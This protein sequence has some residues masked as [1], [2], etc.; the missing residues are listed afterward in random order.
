MHS[1]FILLYFD[2]MPFTASDDSRTFLRRPHQ[3]SIFIKRCDYNTSHNTQKFLPHSLART[4]RVYANPTFLATISHESLEKRRE[5]LFVRIQT[6][7]RKF[8]TRSSFAFST[9]R[10]GARERV[11]RVFDA[12]LVL[13]TIFRQSGVVNLRKLVIYSWNSSQ[14]LRE[15]FLLENAQPS[16]E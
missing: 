8:D 6:A 13:L 7:L 10:R 4:I 9:R 16:L 3:V 15:R 12:R 11:I 5:K 2:I 1:Y 14:A